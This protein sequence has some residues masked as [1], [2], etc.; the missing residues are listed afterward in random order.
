MFSVQKRLGVELFTARPGGRR[1][2]L[3]RSHTRKRKISA[4]IYIHLPK[5][6]RPSFAWHHLGD[7]GTRNGVEPGRNEY[8]R[9]FSRQNKNAGSQ[10]RSRPM[11]RGPRL[12]RNILETAA[13][14]HPS[15][16]RQNRA[17]QSGLSHARRRAR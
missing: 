8:A 2:P 17:A 14:P 9:R 10:G 4:Q 12:D 5:K 16:P 3:N 13:V 7:G 1:E 11:D 15:R 6:K